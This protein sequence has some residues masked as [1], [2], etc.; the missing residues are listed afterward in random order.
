MYENATSAFESMTGA[1]ANDIQAYDL[2]EYSHNECAMSAISGA[3]LWFMS[4]T[5]SQ[6]NHFRD[7]VNRAMNGR[8]SMSWGV[9]WSSKMEKA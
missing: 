9:A 4:R 1:G 3:V 6:L 2:G 8:C 7:E 5:L